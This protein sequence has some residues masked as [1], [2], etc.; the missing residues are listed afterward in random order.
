MV[1]GVSIVGVVIVLVVAVAQVSVV[2][3]IVMVAIKFNGHLR[4]HGGCSLRG[5]CDHVMN[6]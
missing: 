5:E 3:M 6:F 4:N 1:V 2:M